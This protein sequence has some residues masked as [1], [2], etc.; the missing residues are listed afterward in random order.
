MIKNLDFQVGKDK[1]C[2]ISFI[3]VE[4][5]TKKKQINKQNRNKLIDTDNRL[6]ITRREWGWK[7]GEWGKGDQIY[8]DEWKENRRLEVSTV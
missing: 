3:N 2:V 1:N 7:S 4:Y 6:V 5:K 8:G